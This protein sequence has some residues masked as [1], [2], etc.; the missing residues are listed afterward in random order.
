MRFK[1]VCLLV[2]ALV[3]VPSI[4]TA[5]AHRLLDAVLRPRGWPNR[6]RAA[7]EHSTVMASD[8]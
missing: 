6:V 8:R 3:F 2:L 7:S 5:A 4:L 1:A